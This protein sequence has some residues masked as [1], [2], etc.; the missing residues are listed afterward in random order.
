MS[1]LNIG[2]Q[3]F[4]QLP[5]NPEEGL[6]ILS[7]ECLCGLVMELLGRPIFE[8]KQ[9]IE[10]K[11]ATSLWWLKLVNSFKALQENKI[12]FVKSM[13]LLVLWGN[14]NRIAPTIASLKTYECFPKI[15]C[16]L[17]SEFRNTLKHTMFKDV[18]SGDSKTQKLLSMESICCLNR[19]LTPGIDSWGGNNSD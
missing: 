10:Q 4:F 14:Q 18:V 15:M 5:S 2:E 11:K 12:L 17:V 8:E 1:S 9:L 6:W 19:Y 16:V 3:F 7:T 13:T